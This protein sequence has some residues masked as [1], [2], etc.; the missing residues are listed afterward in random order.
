MSDYFEDAPNDDEDYEDSPFADLEGWIG[1]E[2]I[3]Q[4]P[5]EQVERE[6]LD[7]FG[8]ED[9]DEILFEPS[10]IDPEALRGNRFESI[11]D[12]IMYLFDSGILRFSG[13]TLGGEETQIE[14][15]PDS[16]KRGKR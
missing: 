13:V 6:V 3:S 5:F 15:D 10:E 8:I 7:T 16:G 12:A 9:F 4:D 11:Q 1:A 14:V 2:A